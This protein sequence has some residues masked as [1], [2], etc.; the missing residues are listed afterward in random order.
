MVLTA[1]DDPELSKHIYDLAKARHFTINVADVPPL[2]DFY[3]GSVIRRGPLQVMISTNGRGPRLAN[4]VRRMIEAT[5]PTNVGRA[6]DNIGDLRAQLRKVEGGTDKESVKKRMEFMVRL[7]D[8]WSIDELSSMTKQE[9]VRILEGFTQIPED[10]AMTQTSSSGRY[11]RRL[12]CPYWL[13]QLVNPRFYY[14][15]CRIPSR[16]IEARRESCPVYKAK[17]SVEQSNRLAWFGGSIDA[18]LGT[19]LIAGTLL[20]AAATLFGQQLQR[21]YLR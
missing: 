4:R 6:I 10:Y 14:L 2:C 9:Q 11:H 3:F 1:L 8:S 18:W 19:G 20:G 21:R 16:E 7:T 13:L 15:K 17:S 5:I 12:M